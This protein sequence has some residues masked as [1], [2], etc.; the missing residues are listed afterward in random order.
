MYRE[1]YKKTGLRIVCDSNGKDCQVLTKGWKESIDLSLSCFRSVHWT[2]IQYLRN[3]GVKSSITLP[4]LINGELWGMYVLHSYITPTHPTIEERIMIE[5]FAS[6][7]TL[8]IES[9]EK[10]LWASKKLVLSATMFKKFNYNNIYEFFQH[11]Y[12]ELLKLF[13]AHLIIFY[14]E[15][16]DVSVFGDETISLTNYGYNIISEKCDMNDTIAISK[17]DDTLLNEQTLNGLGAGVVFCKHPTFA[18]AVIRRKEICD[19]NWG[20]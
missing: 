12:T 5:V 11:H 18:M 20:K 9:F 17:F 7:S 19:V 8:H 14:N 3:M 13:D 2:H 15:N 6:I 10:E 16:R 1:L 4:I